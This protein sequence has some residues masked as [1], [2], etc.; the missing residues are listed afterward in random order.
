MHGSDVRRHQLH[1]L[2]G[3]FTALI[4]WINSG[5]AARLTR[6]RHRLIGFPKRQ[7]A[8]ARIGRHQVQQVRRAGARQADDDNRFFDLD[9]MDFRMS[10]EGIVDQQSA[11]CM[12]QQFGT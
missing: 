5:S 9:S 2:P 7:G 12:L 8:Q 1:V 3:L 11:R 6:Q 10:L 4:T